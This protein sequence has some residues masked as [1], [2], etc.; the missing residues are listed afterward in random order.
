MR[1]DKLYDFFNISGVDNEFIE[2]AIDYYVRNGRGHTA[3]FYK[4]DKRAYRKIHMSLEVL[5]NYIKVLDD[6]GLAERIL[7]IWKD[8]P[9]IH[10]GIRGDFHTHTEFSDGM[11]TMETILRRAKAL[12]YSWIA[13]TD[14]ALNPDNRLYTMSSEEFIRQTETARELSEEIGIRVYHS[15]EANITE[16]GSPDIPDDIRDN[17]SFALAS[18][19]RLYDHPVDTVLKRIEKAM[20]DEKVIALTHPFF[21]LDSDIYGEFTGDIADIVQ[22]YGKAVELNMFPNYFKGNLLLL[23]EIKRRDMKVIFST[24]EHC[25]NGMYRMRFAGYFIDKLLPEQV[26]NF[27]EEPAA[28]FLPAEAVKNNVI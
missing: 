14:H 2:Y 11:D 22:Q 6:D 27:S 23:D 16:D 20:S 10:R 19:H 8:Y 26:L 5:R 15:I 9:A 12:G 21:A 17:I 7:R 1:K 13:L 25:A 3:D 24:D 4:R 18:L 28:E